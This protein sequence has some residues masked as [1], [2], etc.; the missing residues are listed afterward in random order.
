M[1]RAPERCQPV[2]A[3]EA[4]GQNAEGRNDQPLAA[5]E[6]GTTQARAAVMD[7]RSRMIMGADFRAG[8]ASSMMCRKMPRCR[9]PRRLRP[10]GTNLVV[11]TF[12]PGCPPV[13]EWLQSACCLVTC[14]R[15]ARHERHRQQQQP[16]CLVHHGGKPLDRLAVS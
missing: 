4:T 15:R 12:D 6:T 8:V 16:R 13:P 5:H 14:A 9:P 1:Y 2:T 10:G 7:H 3:V 11:V